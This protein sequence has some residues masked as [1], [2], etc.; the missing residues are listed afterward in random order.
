MRRCSHT[1][2]TLGSSL[3]YHSMKKSALLLLV[4]VLT[5]SSAWAQQGGGPGR[6][7]GGGVERGHPGEREARGQREDLRAL[8]R[9]QPMPLQPQQQ[10][11]RGAERRPRQLSP[12]ER[13]A[14]RDQLRQQRGENLRRPP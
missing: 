10:D 12:E 9:Q 11:A 8:I 5:G 1:M 4:W 2:G 14:L 13:M 7:P 6:A 3:G